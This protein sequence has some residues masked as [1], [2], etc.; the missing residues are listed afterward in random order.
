MNKV[1]LNTISLNNSMTNIVGGIPPKS[2][3]S[4]NEDVIDIPIGISIMTIDNK[5][6]TPEEWDTLTN[7]VAEGV[8]I[9]TGDHS[10]ILSAEKLGNGVIL[11][12]NSSYFDNFP[13]YI[14]WLP[15]DEALLDFNGEQ[16]TNNLIR[17]LKEY[18]EAILDVESNL[19][20]FYVNKYRFPSGASGYLP[21]AGEMYIIVQNRVEI[22]DALKKIGGKISNTTK[23]CRTSTIRG[24]DYAFIANT[25][26]KAIKTALNNSTKEGNTNLIAMVARKLK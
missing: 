11:L 21:S 5:F 4:E 26:I 17:W 25:G 15:P 6:Y 23:P 16:N 20:L 7:V 8:S 19:A 2:N 12:P 14:T 18:D 3:T 10:F 9:N 13:D 24:M 22:G 1:C